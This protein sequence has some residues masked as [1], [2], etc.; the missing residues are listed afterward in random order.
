V[1]EPKKIQVLLYLQSV[2][3]ADH[4]FPAD[5]FQQMKAFLEEAALYRGSDALAVELRF[6]QKAILE[7]RPDLKADTR[8]SCN[9]APS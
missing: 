5:N 2:I 1:Y 6:N 4:G 7:A 3:Q 9:S 8:P